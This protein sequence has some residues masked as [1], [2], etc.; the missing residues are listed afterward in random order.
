M[1]RIGSLELGNWEVL[2]IHQFLSG[3]MH[4]FC[5]TG[6]CLSAV[7]KLYIFGQNQLCSHLRDSEK[8]ATALGYILHSLVLGIAKSSPGT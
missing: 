1:N 2:F 3:F 6:T 5:H 8:F 4:K 7:W